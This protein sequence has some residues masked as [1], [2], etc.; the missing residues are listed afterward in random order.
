MA[1]PARTFAALG[2]PTRLRIVRRLGAGGALS[3]V[4]LT[5][6]ARVT[7]QAITKHLTLLQ[8][9]GLVRSE[10]RGRTRRFCLDPR[11]LDQAQ[12]DIAIISAQWDAALERL[13]RFV[14]R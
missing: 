1:D 5:R 6:G 12:R 13:R 10:R 8:R 4:E 14:E 3:I 11:P 2:D 7:R 9:A